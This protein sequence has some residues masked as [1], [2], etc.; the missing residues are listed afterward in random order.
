M[1]CHHVV[2]VCVC[3]C[4]HACVCVCVCV[5]VW[6]DLTILFRHLR[7]TGIGW[8]MNKSQLHNYLIPF[9]CVHEA[10]DYSELCFSDYFHVL[11]NLVKIIS[12]DVTVNKAIEYVL[13]PVQHQSAL[14]SELVKVFY[15]YQGM[16]ILIVQFILR[17]SNIHC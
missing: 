17:P 2:C 8:E 14:I 12:C 10:Q 15:L 6:S 16:Q 7:Y 9:V 11:T 3:V 1:C 13:T 4:V 5:C